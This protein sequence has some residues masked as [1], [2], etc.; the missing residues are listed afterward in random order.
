MLRN[1]LL[2]LAALPL[3]FAINL[4]SPEMKN[5]GEADIIDLGT[6]GPGQTVSI[7]ID[8]I[9]KAGGIHGIG[10]QYDLAVVTDIPRGWTAEPSKLYQNP[11][12]LTIT[13]S[14][15]TPEGDYSAKVVVV[16]EANGEGLGN[17]SF[18]VRLHVTYDVL[19]A[20]VSPPYRNVGPGQPARFAITIVNKGSAS[21]VFDVS[22]T[23]SKRWEFRKPIYVPAQSSRT[24]YYEIVGDE[25]ETYRMTINVVS[26]AS[27]KIS[28]QKN[29]TLFVRSDLLGDYRATN[30]GV[31]LFPVFESVVYSLAGL[32][33]NLFG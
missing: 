10:G 22:A 30:N 23:G 4:V 27:S 3:A 5:V 21:D 20:D 8:P 12:H 1:I 13:A 19:S 17:V 31:L 7:Q 15:D 9:T 14:P 24:I 26:L 11:L 16:D 2:I 28:E 33:S 6:V 18:T 25:E 29:V 32:I